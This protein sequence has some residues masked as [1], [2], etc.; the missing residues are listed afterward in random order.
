MSKVYV[1]DRGAGK[2]Y[3]LVNKYKLYKALGYEPKVIV[4]TR[5][6]IPR[7]LNQ[8]V[9]RDDII[10]IIQLVQDNGWIKVARDKKNI[11]IF[12]DVL[13]TLGRLFGCPILASID[14]RDIS[15]VTKKSA[16]IA[17]SYDSLVDRAKHGPIEAKILVNE[18]WKNITIYYDEIINEIYYVCSGQY[19]LITPQDKI[20]VE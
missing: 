12:D 10:P 14:S 18:E 2:S 6:Q 9:D 15:I 19:V 1:G 5:D 8:G 3:N 20:Y 16:S 7:Y 11:L 13:Y 17:A 4:Q